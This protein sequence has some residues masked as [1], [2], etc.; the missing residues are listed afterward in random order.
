MVYAIEKNFDLDLKQF[1]IATPLSNLYE[2]CTDFQGK[3]NH[4]KF[5]CLGIGYS[6]EIWCDS[7]FDLLTVL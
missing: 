4:S 6:I 1:L 3:S 7:F 2:I 5:K